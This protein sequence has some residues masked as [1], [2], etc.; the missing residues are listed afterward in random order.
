MKGF[1]SD[2]LRKASKRGFESEEGTLGEGKAVDRTVEDGGLQ[3][4]FAWQPGFESVGFL[5][6]SEMRSK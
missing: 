6:G 3:F 5:V 2:C 1:V 4:V